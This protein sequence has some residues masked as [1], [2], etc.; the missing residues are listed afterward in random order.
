MRNIII[1]IIIF[2]KKIREEVSTRVADDPGLHTLSSK[3][4]LEVAVDGSE[5]AVNGT[6]KEHVARVRPSPYA[7]RRWMKELKSLRLLLSAARNQLTTARRRGE[8]VAEAVTRVK[9]ARRLYMIKI[10]Q[11]KREHSAEFLDN[12]DNEGKANAYVKASRATVVTA[13]LCWRRETRG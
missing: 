1:I 13:H 2:S 7:K 6:L 9:L 4:E 8:D 10:E 3:V 12:R 5:A 11:C